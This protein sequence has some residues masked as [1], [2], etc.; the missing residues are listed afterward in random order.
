MRAQNRC[1]FVGTDSRERVTNKREYKKKKGAGARVQTD[2]NLSAY[3]LMQ[4]TIVLINGYRNH[5]EWQE[6]N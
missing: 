6:N 1:A 3:A 5:F 2:I 4:K